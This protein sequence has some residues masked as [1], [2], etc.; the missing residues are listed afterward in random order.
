MEALYLQVWVYRLYPQGDTGIKR[1]V[2]MTQAEFEARYDKDSIYGINATEAGPTFYATGSPLTVTDTPTTPPTPTTPTTNP[3]APTVVPTP[4]SGDGDEGTLEI[5]DTTEGVE[6]E[7]GQGSTAVVLAVD[8]EAVDSD[9]ELLR[10]DVSFMGTGEGEETSSDTKDTRVWKTFDRVR[11]ILNGEVIASRTNLESD[12]FVEMTDDSYRLR[13]SGLEE[14]IDEDDEARLEV[15]VRAM[16]S[17]STS[18]VDHTWTVALIHDSIRAV[19]EAGVQQYAGHGTISES[20]TSSEFTITEQAAGLTFK[21]SE[22]DIE[23]QV[24]MS[25]E[26]E[27]EGITVF[28][29]EVE[30]DEN[31]ADA[32]LQ[33]L[34]FVVRDIGRPRGTSWGNVPKMD[35]LVNNVS[36]HL[37]GEEL[38]DRDYQDGDSWFDGAQ[39]NVLNTAIF[40][41]LNIEFEPGEKKT[42]T[43]KVDANKA[44]NGHHGKDFVSYLVGYTYEYGNDEDLVINN[45]D[46][47]NIP[48]DDANDHS[49]FVRALLRG[50]YLYINIR[51]PEVLSAMTPTIERVEANL[52][53]AMFKLKIAAPES[54]DVYLLNSCGGDGQGISFGTTAT[55]DK[56]IIETID[57]AEEVGTAGSEELIKIE[58]G[59]TATFTI[60]IDVVGDGSRKR[61]TLK[62]IKWNNRANAAMTA[63]ASEN[64]LSLSDLELETPSLYLTN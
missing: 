62:Q 10:V 41:N 42:F 50:P 36:L 54:N 31:A 6:D 18:R 20:D 13:F 53:E 59:E 46:S 3:D 2:N 21:V 57:N 56:C 33:E 64:V 1:H 23:T 28:H 5:D 51:G 43:V 8:L 25:T 44:V 19:D 26:E 58:K 15:E 48:L 52:A 55:A 35:Q 32:L 30:N 38:D 39:E 34:R 14:V 49:Q 47:S 9:I 45:S 60:I 22:M 40:N 27:T 7:I 16:G 24:R 29:L 12:D 11:L 61:V 17:L 37:D 63:L 4:R